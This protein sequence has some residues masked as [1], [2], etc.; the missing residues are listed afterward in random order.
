MFRSTLP[1]VQRVEVGATAFSLI[2]DTVSSDS[3][4]P[5]PELIRR[6]ERPGGAQVAT[7]VSRST[8][9]LQ[10]VVHGRLVGAVMENL[11][12]SGA[13]KDEIRS[14]VGRVRNAPTTPGS[15][16]LRVN[17]EPAAGF[18]VSGERFRAVG[19][20]VNDAILT[21]V[22]DTEGMLAINVG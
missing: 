20:L 5:E 12:T 17:G 10:E 3:E 19:V 2:E 21:V 15:A 11:M 9:P 1:V 14:A 6:W 7:R 13:E 8:E 4:S 16:V 22:S 18:A